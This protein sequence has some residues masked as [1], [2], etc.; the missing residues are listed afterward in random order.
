MTADRLAPLHGVRVL[1][2]RPRD[3]AYALAKAIEKSGGVAIVC[4][5]LEIVRPSDAAAAL[6][7][8]RRVREFAAALFV[9]HNAVEFAFALYPELGEHL[10]SIKTYAVGEA[11]GLRLIE[12]G[13]E[14]P[15][16]PNSDY[17]SE[18]LLAMPGLQRTMVNGQQMLIVRGEGGRETLAEGLTE[19]GSVVEYAEVYRRRRATPDLSAL[20]TFP[21]DIIIATS[22]E[23]LDSLTEMFSG[24]VGMKVMEKPLVVPAARLG[25]HAI[26]CGFS[27]PIAQATSARD[28]DLICACVE[29]LCA[30]T[31]G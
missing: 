28:A 8:L 18:A 6:A 9:S 5:A 2:T 29:W 21:P 27:G 14:Q 1:V 11:T 10:S 16:W 13:V 31:N 17:G 15:Q 20:Q 12:A 7:T 4:P 22:A 19:R 30:T 24:A 3:Q 23:V 26:Q 25:E